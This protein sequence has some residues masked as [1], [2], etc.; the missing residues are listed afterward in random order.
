MNGQFTREKKIQHWRRAHIVFILLCCFFSCAA[1][2]SRRSEESNKQGWEILV[3]CETNTAPKTDL[4][5]SRKLFER[6]LKQDKN[7][8]SAL[9]GLGRI[10]HLNGNHEEAIVF[11][12]RALAIAPRSAACLT[13]RGNC[14]WHVKRE[15]AALSDYHAARDLDSSNAESCLNLGM[16]YFERGDNVSSLINYNSAIIRRFNNY[17]LA[18]YHRAKTLSAMSMDKEAIKDLKEVL[19]RDSNYTKAWIDLGTLYAVEKRNALA[20]A[21]FNKALALSENCASCYSG[22]GLALQDSGLIKEAVADFIRCRD[23]IPDVGIVHDALGY[24][25]LLLTDT[26]A[27]LNEFNQALTLDSLDTYALNNRGQISQGKGKYEAAASD[28]KLSLALNPKQEEVYEYYASN[29][30]YQRR[31]GEAIGIFEKALTITT[32]KGR[33][34]WWLA[35][36]KKD[37]GLLRDALVDLKNAFKEGITDCHLPESIGQLHYMLKEY[38]EALP[39]YD[40]ALVICPDDKLLYSARGDVY[41]QLKNYPLAMKDWEQMIRMDTA[42]GESYN[43]RGMVYMAMHAYAKA[44]A[45]FLRAIRLGTSLAFPYNNLANC[46]MKQNRKREACEYWQKALDNGYKYQPE[47]KTEF[48]IDNPVE[49]IKKNCR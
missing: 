24:A 17:P 15:E 22:R 3:A 1:Q 40:S 26:T 8:F 49:L 7:N 38:R 30:Y 4:E 19:S 6:A 29:S 32:K 21:A 16:L 36:V 12:D 45:D 44:E 2:S 33:I 48:G 28:F 42:N 14:N 11:Y 39:Y 41:Y 31:Y 20:I 46:Y 43:Q 18:H 10:E 23:L 34:L 47:W 5:K 13:D 27:A 25:L 37:S 35:V 9:Q